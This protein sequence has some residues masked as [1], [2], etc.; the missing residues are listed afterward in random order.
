MTIRLFYFVADTYPAWRFD[1]NELFGKELPKKGVHVTWSMRRSDAGSCTKVAQDGQTVYLPLSLGRRSSASRIANR[2][3]EAF[4]EV[5]WFLRLVLGPRYDIIQVRD[6]RYLAGFWG[7]L[8]ARLT[9]ARFVYWLSFPF[10]ENDAEKGRRAR[11]LKRLFLESRARITGWWLYRVLLCL[12]DHVFVQS[13]EMQRDVAAYGVPWDRMTPVPM[14]IPVR[15]LDMATAHTAVSEPGTIAYVGTLAAV[16][17]LDVIVD[18]F[19]IVRAAC[20]QARLIVIGDGDMPAERAA[21]EAQVCRLGLAGQ[22][23]F[24]GFLPVDEVWKIL[25]TAAI[26]LS[27]IFVDRVLKVG[28]PTKLVEYL[29]MRKPVVCNDHP[30]QSAIIRDSNAGLSVAWGAEQFAA[31]MIWMLR[32]PEE[33]Q[34]MGERGPAWVSENRTYPIIAASVFARYRQLLGQAA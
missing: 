21:L 29:A 24:T 28:S 6:D 10:P 1:V 32:H 34:A 2:F 30:E 22:V 26:G 17:R 23:R 20:P 4:C 31:A 13:E 3:L 33:A 16:R 8:A 11:G 14:A 19:A 7:W 15:L 25:G 9:G 18:A 5:Y 27:P 12:A